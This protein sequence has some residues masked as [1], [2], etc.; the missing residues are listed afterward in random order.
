MDLITFELKD[1]VISMDSEK[2]IQ[3][4]EKVNNIDPN[5]VVENCH[6]YRPFERDSL[7]NIAKIPNEKGLSRHF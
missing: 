7:K 6:N 1:I 2:D 4:K 3:S 5:V